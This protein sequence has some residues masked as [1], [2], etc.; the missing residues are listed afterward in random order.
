MHSLYHVFVFGYS[1][2]TDIRVIANTT[3]QQPLEFDRI[4]DENYY[5]VI[6]AR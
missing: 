3:I 1:V 2:V 4:Y 6:Q 5:Y